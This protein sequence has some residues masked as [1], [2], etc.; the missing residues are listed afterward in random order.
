M[1]T[2]VPHVTMVVSQLKPCFCCSGAS[3]LL[4]KLVLGFVLAS[5]IRL[6]SI[7]YSSYS[8]SLG[9]NYLFIFTRPCVWSDFAGLTLLLTRLI[10]CNTDTLNFINGCASWL[11]KI[12]AILVQGLEDRLR[13]L[14]NYLRYRDPRRVHYPVLRITENFHIDFVI[15]SHQIVKCCDDNLDFL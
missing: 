9:N 11:M 13:D 7:A 5:V 6:S 1:T 3:D 15:L 2:V 10:A 12:A 8:T 14:M 4:A